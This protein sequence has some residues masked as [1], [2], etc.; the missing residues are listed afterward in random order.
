MS[1]AFRVQPVEREL[2][3][4]LAH[5]LRRQGCSTELTREGAIIVTPP[6]ELHDEQ[7][8]LELRLYVRLWEVLHGTRVS[9]S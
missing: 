1:K 8:E 6:H 5:Y 2:A 7:A 9:L 4:A 3:P